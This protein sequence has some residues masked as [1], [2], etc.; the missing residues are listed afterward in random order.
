MRVQTEIPEL[1]EHLHAIESTLR[2]NDGFVA[3][4]FTV[5]EHS[6]QFSAA[7]AEHIGESG[8]LLVSYPPELRVPM[9]H[10]QWADS[11][12]SMEPVGG[13]DGFTVAQRTLFEHWLPLVNATRRLSHVRTSVPRFAVDSWPLRHHLADAGYP[14]M[15]T[16]PAE[17]DPRETV[18][19]WHSSGGSGRAQ[20]EG[21][22][23]TGPRWQL[24][25]LKHLVNHDPTGANQD[26]VPG[27][28]AV[29]TSAS[30]SESGTFENYG[31]LDAMQLLMGFGYVDSRAE[32]VHSVPVVVESPELGKVAVRWRAPRYGRDVDGD[33]AVAPVSRLARDVPSVTD[34]DG[35]LTLRH[36][37]M[38]PD[39]RESVARLLAMLLQSR[40]GMG[41]EASRAAAERLLD[42]LLA[43]NLDYYR[44]LDELVAATAGNAGILAMVAE[45]S[46]RQQERLER[47][48]G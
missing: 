14:V 4:D 41:S 7:I 5:R 32:L 34:E 38:R 6:G 44:R 12:D 27:R 48:W 35:Q 26:P 31:D 24:I 47:M 39:N 18:I 30:S 40:A 29:A 2:A 3:D 33:A 16:S 17:L 25:P 8:R 22:Q 43:S 42:D 46:L 37:T 21:E 45:V 23:N 20:P 10:V 13:L 9:W 36:L 15:R 1:A 28:T 19:G 11:K